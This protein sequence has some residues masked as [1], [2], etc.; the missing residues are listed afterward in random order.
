MA[1]QLC[2][3]GL[4]MWLWVWQSIGIVA[5]MLTVRLDRRSE[6]LLGVAQERTRAEL[7]EDQEIET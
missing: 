4:R 2:P 5:R 7:R 6:E 3:E 1:L